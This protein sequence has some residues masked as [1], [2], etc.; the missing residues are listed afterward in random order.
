MRILAQKKENK[1][2]I[3]KQFSSKKIKL[4]HYLREFVLFTQTTQ[5]SI[6][7]KIKFV[8]PI[9]NVLIILAIRK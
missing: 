2:T 5:L 3:E 1:L 4:A 7:Q 9:P 6:S 8:H